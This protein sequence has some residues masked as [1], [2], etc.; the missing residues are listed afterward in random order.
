MILLW[1]SLLQRL[2][3]DTTPHMALDQ[4]TADTLHR[5]RIARKEG[6]PSPAWS[7]GEQLP[8]ALVLND[9]EHPAAM[10]Y[11]AQQAHERV[12]GNLPAAP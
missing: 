2:G 9:T 5:C 3:A 11:T 6:G 10:D 12:Y 4:L 7:T 8:V 1:C